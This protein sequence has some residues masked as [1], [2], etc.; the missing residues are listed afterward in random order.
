MINN[1]RYSLPG[2]FRSLGARQILYILLQSMLCANSA[3]SASLCW[4][5][6]FSQHRG[7]KNTEF[8]RDFWLIYSLT[9]LYF[10]GIPFFIRSL[11]SLKC[12]KYTCRGIVPCFLQME[13]AIPTT[14]P[15]MAV[16]R[17]TR[18]EPK[19]TWVTLIF[20]PA[21]NKLLTLREYKQRYGTWYGYIRLWELS[22]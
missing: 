19:A 12:S 18:I 20:R 22:A 1:D 6:G 11:N 5:T 8:H 13:T 14:S 17:C 7:T 9:V 15:I 21:M 4:K 16:V 10:G 2:F 3:P